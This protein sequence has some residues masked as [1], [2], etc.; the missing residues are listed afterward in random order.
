MRLGATEILLIIILAL[1]LFGGGKL[2]GIGK[3]LGRSIKDFKN[4]VK[5][6]NDDKSKQ[7]PVEI[8]DEVKL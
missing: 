1:V 2:A 4:E 7:E 5:D 8:V 3:A 6:S